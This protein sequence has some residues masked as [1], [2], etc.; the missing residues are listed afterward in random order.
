MRRSRWLLIGLGILLTGLIAVAVDIYV[1]YPSSP[2]P[3][4]GEERLVEVEKGVGPKRLAKMLYD[5]GVISSPG[6]F[7]LALG[8]ISQAFGNLFNGLQIEID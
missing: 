6:R 1:V 5:T 7:S 3:G 4:S 8:N 2:G